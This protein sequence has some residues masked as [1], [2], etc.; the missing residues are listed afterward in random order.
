MST[1]LFTTEHSPVGAWASLTFGAPGKGAGIHHEN[2][3]GG[4]NGDLLVAVRRGV[5]TVALPFVEKGSEIGSWRM[6]GGEGIAR[7][8]TPCVDEFVAAEAGLS[9]RV[10]TPHSALPNPKRSGNLQYA[11][12]PAI[13]MEVV[14]DNTGSDEAAT[15]F[16]GV[17]Y[18]GEGNLRPVDWSSKTLCGVGRGGE[19]AAGGDAGEGGDFYGAIG[20][21]CGGDC[22][23]C[24]C[25]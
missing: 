5:Q 12:V 3:G 11:T 15:A 22:G 24:G 1:P 23:R 4:A 20:G 7:E 13:L 19:V 2:I 10:C 6:I 8:L 18:R 25:Y 16:V 21:D 17:R 9:L 14:I